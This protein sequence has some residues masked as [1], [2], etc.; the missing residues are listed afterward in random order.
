MN[1]SSLPTSGLIF[2]W[3]FNSDGEGREITSQDDGQLHLSSTDHVWL[4]LNY[5]NTQVQT[6]LKSP[7]QLPEN[8]VEEL[9]EYV[10][11]VRQKMFCRAEEAHLIFFNDF[12]KEFN[13]K[14]ITTD[15][16]KMYEVI[17]LFNDLSGS[18]HPILEAL[19]EQVVLLRL[20]SGTDSSVRVQIGDEQSEKSLRSTSLV[21]VGYANIGALGILGP[22]RMDYASS[23]TAVNAVANYV[24][25]F[26]TENK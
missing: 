14:N 25:R 23:I 22:T 8:I 24:G 7:E 1:L 21:T 20:L 4:H 13:Q 18:I 19:E 16:L 26:L 17:N 9:Q 12:Q 15:W 2:G 11:R 3:L 10:G 6:W 5:A